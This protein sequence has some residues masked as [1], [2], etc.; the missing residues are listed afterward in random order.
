MSSNVIDE[1]TF[2]DKQFVFKDRVHAGQLLA[3]KLKNHVDRVNVQL[4]AI[5]A[6]GIPVGHTIAKNLDLP[7][8]V[9]IVRKIQIPW[10]TEAGF[11]AV[12]YNGTVLL[13]ES[14]VAQLGLTSEI[15]QWCISQTQQIIRER[16]EKFRGNKPFPDLKKKIVILVDDGLASGS[17]MLVAVKSV[18][19]QTP[20]KIVVAVPTASTGAIEL[21]APSVN[22][23]ICLNIRSGP[24]FAV[25]DAYQ[26]WYDL[27]DE[28]VI[29][30]LRKSWQS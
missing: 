2:R 26:K 7:L 23:L 21:V 13:N 28:E 5:P 1:P 29:E 20:E 16:L 30:I 8:D 11:G 6:G 15:V 12:S 17:T 27:S 24:I 25:A 10:N 22:K 3:T 19:K 14:L 18:Q 4:L 9:I